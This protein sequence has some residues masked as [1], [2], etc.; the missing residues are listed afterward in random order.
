M[1]AGRCFLAV[2]LAWVGASSAEAN[3]L[4][5]IQVDEGIEQLDDL[6][7]RQWQSGMDVD[8]ELLG[9]AD[10]NRRARAEALLDEAL[11]L[12]DQLDAAIRAEAL[13]GGRTNMTGSRWRLY[14]GIAAAA[15]ALLDDGRGDLAEDSAYLLRDVSPRM[16]LGRCRRLMAMLWLR[17]GKRDEAAVAAKTLAED[18]GA[19][20]YERA[21]ASALQLHILSGPAWH[22]AARDMLRGTSAAWQVVLIG[23]SILATAE[24]GDEVI[25]WVV[26]IRNAFERSGVG[27]SEHLALVAAMI[28]RLS[29]TGDPP[30]RPLDAAVRIGAARQAGRAS[31]A[32]AWLGDPDEVIQE[33]RSAVY[34]ELARC[35]EV[36]G[37]ELGAMRAWRSASKHAQGGG[38]EALDQAA[39]NAAK[40]INVGDDV[41]EAVSVLE[42][43]AARGASRPTWILLLAS[44][45]AGRGEYQAAIDRLL[46][47]P[48]KGPEHLRGLA[49]AAECIRIRRRETG[50]WH[51]AD[52]A[53]LMKLLAAASAAADQQ[54]DQVRA[55]LAAPTASTIARIDIDRLIDLGQLTA[56]ETKLSN[57]RVRAWCTAADVACLAAKLAVASG[58]EPA[59]RSAMARLDHDGAS[60]VAQQLLVWAA[61]ELGSDAALD[62]IITVID[63]PTVGGDEAS[64]LAVAEAL[65]MGGRYDWALPFY[66]EM[67]I[68]KPNLLPA[69]LGRSEC[70]IHSEDR[71]DL[72][73]AAAG[74][75]RV[76][77][78]PRAE[79]P[80]RW[81]LANIRLLEVLRRAG[82]DPVRIDARLARLRLIDP[83][84]GAPEG[85]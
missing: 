29:L 13:D 48:P 68:R 63:Q 5:E 6:L 32:K 72:S 35:H 41:S 39:G 7:M 45:E 84:I 47:M 20:P 76:A 22:A 3:S 73:E 38:G 28:E 36:S 12:T 40:L 9:V 53:C 26:P 77:A 19:A 4:S 42:E 67:L 75:R 70:L 17:Q 34:G 62:L 15:T 61:F 8:L 1:I 85:P 83:T 2:V 78:M 24:G 56:A 66:E 27:S 10:L 71:G 25:E 81:R 82:T 18:P 21:A 50:R 74:Y 58:D 14:R 59:F 55:A 31:A 33:D 69:V 43:A 65:R 60:S 64:Q 44:V 57:P 52:E 51:A 80:L 23:E 16:D 30:K 79:D 37:N 46:D 49:A 11:I 54:S